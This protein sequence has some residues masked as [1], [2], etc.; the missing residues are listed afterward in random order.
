MLDKTGTLTLGRPTVTGVHLLADLDERACLERARALEASCRHPIARAFGEPGSLAAEAARHFAG[1][2]VEA[3][4][5][6]LRY[7]IGT[8][9]FCAE[10]RGQAAPCKGGVF[11]ASEHAWLAAF[12][13]EDE[14]RHDA[15]ELIATLRKNAMTVHLASGDDPVLVERLA[16][17]L[18]V[19]RWQGGMRPE[20]KHDYVA[21]LQGEGRVVAMVGDGLN[22]APVLALADVSFA[23][24]SGADAAQL[25]ADVILT[26][27]RL[28]S[29][30]D[31][32][33]IARAALHL[34]R[35]NFAWALAYNAVAL[36]LAALGWIG[37]W[38]AALGMGAS[39][40]IVLANAS[41]PLARKEAWKAST[42]SYPSPSLSYS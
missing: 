2:G 34:V 6:A 27:D 5:G 18:G 39:S 38:Q 42:S 4:I 16:R 40:L 11:L 20:A 31:T 22:D 25:R 9:A 23:M 7:R 29:V 33:G 41:R 15:A 28:S 8:A 1:Q 37:P 3:R 17:R 10:L 14:L 13:L 30:S 26:G 32:F 19:A 35:Q 12:H 24:G 21:R 36:P